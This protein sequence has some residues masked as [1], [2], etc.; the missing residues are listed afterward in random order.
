MAIN[1]S[2]Q[3]LFCL[4]SILCFITAAASYVLK[5]DFSK[6]SIAPAP[7]P[8]V[9]GSGTYPRATLLADGSILS[10][11][12]TFSGTNTVLMVAKSTNGGLNWTV[13]GSIASEVT[14]TNDLDN[15]NVHALS[16]GRIL[17]AFRNHDQ[18]AEGN[19]S[20]YFYRLVVCYSDDGGFTWSY[21]STPRT[22]GT[23]G[24]GLWEPFLMNALDGSLMMY[25]SYETSTTG[26][27]QDSILIRSNDGG[28]TWSSDQT[29]SGAGITCRDGML[30]VARLGAGSSSLIAVFESL[31]PDS[32]IHAITSTDDGSTWGNRRV[33]YASAIAG[34]DQ[35]A[36]QVA[37][38]N[39]QI[40]V[41]FQTNEDDLTTVTGDWDVKA[42][43]STDSGATWSQKTRVLDSCNWAGE[44][45]VDNLHLLVLCGSGNS[46][47]A[48]TMVLS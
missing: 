28:A 10:C 47:L 40:V 21:L 17:A 41:S 23:K 4:I 8:A 37:Y 29:I 46:A 12:T 3:R 7:G 19:S 42:I 32:G 18:N 14:Q 39:G 48:Q 45:T 6:R 22:S 27:D 36:P 1:Q 34:A 9:I 26:N 38:I 25:Y 31:S 5:P 35:G 11:F 30:G 15:C 20:W 43:V 13:I 2:T 16:S 44:L 24:L 33:V